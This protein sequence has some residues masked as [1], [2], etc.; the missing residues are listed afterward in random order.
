MFEKREFRFYKG[1]DREA[2]YRKVWDWWTARGFYVAQMAPYQ[3]SGTSYYSK[4]GL[5]REVFLY[6]NDI[7]DGTAI[8]MTMRAKITDE[9]AVGGVAVAALIS[10]PLAA[11]GGAISYHEYEKDAK[12]LMWYFWQYI[13]QETKVQG[14]WWVPPSTPP[15]PPEGLPKAETGPCGNCGALLPTDWKACPYCGN[16]LAE[17]AKK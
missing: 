4:I 3:L 14:T 8:D 5:R 7:E 6:I 9:G 15:Q 11:V 12:E 17:E 10:L 16:E 2:V 1:V 13:D